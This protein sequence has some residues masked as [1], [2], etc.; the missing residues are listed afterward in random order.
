MKKI[1]SNTIRKHLEQKLE[2]Y[3]IE[4]LIKE[5]RKVLRDLM[6]YPAENKWQI[7]YYKKMWNL[8]LEY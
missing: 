6:I 1:H 3:S 8:L 7:L 2:L 4:E 5:C